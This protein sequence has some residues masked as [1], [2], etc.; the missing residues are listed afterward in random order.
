MRELVKYTTKDKITYGFTSYDFWT[1][2]D[3]DQYIVRIKE[4]LKV[5]Y[6]SIILIFQSC[7]PYSLYIE[8]NLKK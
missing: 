6:K 8:V 7:A 1:E 2:K 4:D 3:I 5:D